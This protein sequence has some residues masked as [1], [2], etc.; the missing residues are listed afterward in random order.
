VVAA[1]LGTVGKRS[2]AKAFANSVK[3]IEARS[4]ASAA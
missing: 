1:V 2:L 4:N 3:A